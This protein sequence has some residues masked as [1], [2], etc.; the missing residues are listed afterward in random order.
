MHELPSHREGGLLGTPPAFGAGGAV[1]KGA[2]K[3]L[4]SV[5]TSLHIVLEVLSGYYARFYTR[6]YE[7]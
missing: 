1:L 2:E 4:K 3:V 7:C 5:T 6:S